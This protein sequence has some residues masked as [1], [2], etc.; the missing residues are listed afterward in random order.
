MDCRT[1]LASIK[2]CAMVKK[3]SSTLVPAFALVSKKGTPSLAAHC[4]QIDESIGLLI[5]N[6]VDWI[7]WPI[8]KIKSGINNQTYLA[9]FRTNYSVGPIALI[10]DQKL[11]AQSLVS[12]PVDLVQ[13]I[14][15]MFER[16]LRV[17]TGKWSPRVLLPVFA[18]GE[19]SSWRLG[20]IK[21]MEKH[22]RGIDPTHITR[23]VVDHNN[24]VCA[25]IIG[26]GDSTETLLSSGIPL[27]TV[28][29]N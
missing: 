2:C 11:F 19:S 29:V 25:S 12:V 13:P 1:N 16:I 6:F 4:W 21:S 22:V 20:V 26:T 14:L 10:A 9:I 7:Y 3:A 15:H 5:P 8:A 18:N 17:W 27:F 23:D 24:A 28:I